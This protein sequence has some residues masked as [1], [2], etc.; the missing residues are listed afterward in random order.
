[1]SKVAIK[2]YAPFY[3]ALLVT[4]IVMVLLFLRPESALGLTVDVDAVKKFEGF[5]AGFK[6][7]DPNTGQPE[8]VVINAEISLAELEF[9]RVTSATLG[10]ES[11]TF[12]ASL[13]AAQEVPPVI[14]VNATGTG[15]F[16]LNAARTELAYK[17]TVETNKLTGLITGAHFHNA[18]AGTNGGVVRP[19]TSDLVGDTFTGTWK[20]TDPQP[21]TN[22]LVDALE[23]GNL[24]IN[25]H[26]VANPP[27]EIRGQVVKQFKDFGTGKAFPAVDLPLP[28]APNYVPVSAELTDFLPKVNGNTQGKLVVDAE[29]VQLLP[30]AF[31]YGYGYRGKLGGG[32]IKFTIRYIPPEIAGTYT[33]TVA[34][35]FDNSATSRTLLAP[36]ALRSSR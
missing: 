13:D 10:I 5:P 3:I 8:T 9:G 24:Y 31:G 19:I 32:K 25:V 14:G 21:L 12:S 6:L 35:Y 7:L 30:D 29:L 26:T 17:I 15:T 16:T 36:R 28:A 22:V 23:A 1:M 4:G 27:G 20:S 2:R 33:A 18:A 11:R 34:A